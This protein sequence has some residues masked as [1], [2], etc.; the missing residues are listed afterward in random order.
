MTRPSIRI[1]AGAGFSGDRIEPALDLI[2]H[3]QLDYLAFECLAER[4]IGLAQAARALDPQAGFDPLLETRMRRALPLAAPRGLRIITNMGAA[5]TLAAARKVTQIAREL[6]LSGYCTAAVTGDDV[7]DLVLAGDYPLIDREGTS[8]DLGESIV[9]ANAYLGVAGIVQALEQGADTV[10]TGRVCDPALFLAPLIHELGWAMDDWDLLG[11]GTVVGHLLECA[12]QV[13]GGYFADPGVKDVPDLAR[14]G[15][16]YADVAR[17]GRAVLGKLEGSG[18]RLDSMTV[19][20][21]LLY[22]ILDPAAYWQADVCADFRQVRI[23]QEAPDRVSIAGGKGQPAPDTLKVSI[24]Y[25]DG[26]MGEGQISYAGPGA[27]ARGR[28]AIEIVRER[29]RLIGARVEDLRCDLIGMDAVDQRGMGGDP[30]EVRVRIAGRVKDE[31]SA[32]VIGAEVEALYTN[33]PMGGGGVTR[34]TRRVL[35]V[36][37]CLL[38]RAMVQPRV[39]MEVA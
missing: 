3:G 24:A 4:T 20:E 23:V 13:C 8:R 17:D 18:G 32:R 34:S 38:P 28:L 12:G 27:V 25:H 39:T 6:G 31:A 35:A 9:S 33:G 7:L 22:E 16:P 2:E 36:A 29:L 11:Q 26:H 14:L 37:S 21:Q 10:I 30:A 19:K 15:F 1:G 5:N